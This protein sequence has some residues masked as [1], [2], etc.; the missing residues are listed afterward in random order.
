[1]ES[2]KSI[3]TCLL[4]SFSPCPSPQLLIREN[5]KPAYKQRE[6]CNQYPYPS[7]L[8]SATINSWPILFPLYPHHSSACFPH[9]LSKPIPD[10]NSFPPERL[11][12]ASLKDKDSSFETEP[13]IPSSHQK[14]YCS[15][16]SNVQSTS[17]PSLRLKSLPISRSLEL[18]HFTR[19]RETP[20]PPLKSW[21]VCY[22]PLVFLFAVW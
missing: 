17:L 18:N 1:M 8:A 12:H 13:P 21:T 19:Q 20:L 5:F 16:S 4:L 11:R 9:S 10:I 7:L 6:L 22:F 2:K 14:H 3:L 15:T